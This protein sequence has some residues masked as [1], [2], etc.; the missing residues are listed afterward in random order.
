MASIGLRPP[1]PRHPSQPPSDTPTRRRPLAARCALLSFLWPGLGQVAGGARRR[2]V[3]LVVFTAILLVGALVVLAQQGRDTLIGEAVDTRVLV[4]VLIANGLIAVYRLGAIADAARLG[5][6]ARGT[7]VTLAI[8]AT[9]V[10]LP[11]AGVA[12]YAYTAY[13]T[14]TEVFEESEPTD[15]LVPVADQFDVS[16]AAKIPA[17]G[18]AAADPTSISAVGRTPEE[19]AAALAAQ[20]EAAK[21]LPAWQKRGRLNL[22]LLGADA[23]PGRSGLRTDTMMVATID[24]KTHRAALFS[25]PRNMGGVPLP[26]RAARGAGARFPDILNALHA[27][28]TA[29]PDLFPGGKDPGVTALKQTLGQLTGLPID[30]YVM[31]DFRGFHGLVAALGGV[32][33]DIPHAVLDRVSPYERGGAWIRI[34]LQPGRQHLTA[35]QAFAYVRARSTSSD[36][37]RIKRQRCVIAELADAT[38][39]TTVLRSFRGLA[40]TFRENFSTDIP[41]KHLPELA[42]LATSINMGQVVSIGFTPPEFTSGVTAAGKNMPDIPAIRKAVRDALEKAPAKSD[43]R[44]IGGGACF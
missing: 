42:R 4:G 40:K 28:G 12:W 30:Y 16:P 41:A 44:T 29:H 5:Y 15:V 31:V 26:P 35:D 10:I 3:F 9:L 37:A 13:D 43:P 23:G 39:P 27:F 20:K 36:W 1:R 14:V 32:T 7:I 18:L 33:L 25:V 38:G 22:V 21:H 34:D 6:R 24:L 2:G 19:T 8:L 17:G 11:Q